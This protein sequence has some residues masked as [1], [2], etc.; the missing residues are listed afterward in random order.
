MTNDA[1]RSTRVSHP[2]LRLEVVG[3]D[4]RRSSE[5][6]VFCRYQQRSV[7]VGT[8]CACTH[9]DAIVTTPSPAVNCTITVEERDLA[10]DPDGLRTAVGTMLEGA[11]IAIDPGTTVRDALLLLNADDSRSIAVVNNTHTM[12]GV[13]HESSFLP[14][15]EEASARSPASVRSPASTVTPLPTQQR[16]DDQVL[17]MMSGAIAI[18][19]RLPIRKALEV[20]AGAHLREATVID[21][22]GVPLG[23]FRD[24]A[25]LRWLVTARDR[26]R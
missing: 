12:V 26:S 15:L 9:C 23:V 18:H 16:A 25:G 4:G 3:A 13:V 1:R 22:A 17:R 24:V 7:A 5:H 21:D 2:I 20:L 14:M 6:R 10:P 11:T 19:E 8:C